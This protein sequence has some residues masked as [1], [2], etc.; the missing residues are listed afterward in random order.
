[1]KIIATI[2]LLI[3]SILSPILHS[4]D[5]LTFDDQKWD[6][7]QV[8]TSNLTVGNYSFSS[9]NNFY[10]NYG[11][12]FN[13]NSISLYYIFLNAKTDL[14]TITPKN[15]SYINF[16][17]FD[18]CQVS[19]SST[20]NL[21]IEGWDGSTKLYSKSFSKLNTWQ[22]LNL[23][24]NK[25]NKI[26]IRLSSTTS[27]LIDY[28]FDNFSFQGYKQGSNNGNIS[29]SANSAALSGDVQLKTKSGSIGTK[30]LY[31][32]NTYST[33]KFSVNLNTIWA[34]VCLGKNVF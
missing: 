14:V 4:Q 18:V 6:N 33:A 27:G 28:N 34:M 26:I 1:M 12:K 15:G 9:N 16:L 13:I 23:N 31:F 19:E 24:F 21:I 8:L 30:V 29:Y 25:I 10:T 7:D 20:A 17:S 2:S 11:Y 3:L 5:L 32:L 22:T